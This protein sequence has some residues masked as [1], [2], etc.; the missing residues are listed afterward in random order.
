M[1][2]WLPF[3]EAGFV[4]WHGFAASHFQWFFNI[5]GGLGWGAA[6]GIEPG[7]PQGFPG[8]VLQ[9]IGGKYSGFPLKW[10]FR[11]SIPQVRDWALRAERKI[12][13][14]QQYPFNIL[15]SVLLLEFLMCHEVF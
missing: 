12:S 4:P 7:C 15:L 2:S 3:P 1:H 10:D 5:E 6:A 8:A 14:W 9:P 11:G 13:C